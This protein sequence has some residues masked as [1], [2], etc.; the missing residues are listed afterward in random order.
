MGFFQAR[1]ETKELHSKIELRTRYYRTSFKKV[2][3]VLGKLQD[4]MD[5]EIQQ[6]NEQFGEIQLLSNGYDMVLTIKEFTP[7]ETGIDIM[8]NYFSTFGFNRPKKRIIEL[9]KAL[10]SKLPYKGQSLHP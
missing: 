3:D 10:D 9:Y 4:E 1:E 6:V 5:F 8:C 7:S 2:L